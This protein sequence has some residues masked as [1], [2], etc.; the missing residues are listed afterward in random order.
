MKGVGAATASGNRMVKG[1][2][3]FDLAKAND[4]KR[5]A[6]IAADKGFLQEEGIKPIVQTYSYGVDTVD[7]VVSTIAASLATVIVSE[8]A[9]G[10]AA[11]TLDTSHCAASRSDALAPTALLPSTEPAREA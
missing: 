7:A 10:F 4:V 1:E 11:Y 5:M 8:T 2:A 3:P 9:A 6:I